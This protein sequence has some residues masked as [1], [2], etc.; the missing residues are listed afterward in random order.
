VARFIAGE[1]VKTTNTSPAWLKNVFGRELLGE[2]K[3]QE[4][5]PRTR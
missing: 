4:I 1:L 3:P 5:S 2:A